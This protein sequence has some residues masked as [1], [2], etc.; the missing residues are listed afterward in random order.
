MVLSFVYLEAR[1]FGGLVAVRLFLGF[2][3]DVIS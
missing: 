1:G 2:C 3:V